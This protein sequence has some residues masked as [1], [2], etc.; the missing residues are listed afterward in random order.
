MRRTICSPSFLFRGFSR[1]VRTNSA[2]A[3]NFRRWGLIGVHQ[4]H[5]PDIFEPI[6]C[7]I[8]KSFYAS[9][10]YSPSPFDLPQLSNGGMIAAFPLDSFT[11]C[12]CADTNG[13]FALPRDDGDCR[14]SKIIWRNGFGRLRLNYDHLAISRYGSAFTVGIDIAAAVQLSDDIR[15]GFSFLNLNRPTIGRRRINCLNFFSRESIASCFRLP[16]CLICDH[17]RCAI[18]SFGPNGGS[19]SADGERRP[20]SR[21]VKRP[22]RDTMRALESGIRQFQWTTAL[23]HTPN[24]D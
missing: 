9:F 4:R 23:Q 8:L 10:F 1:R 18:S 6:S 13:L 17:K 21:R 14:C 22:I 19:V 2:A 15:W 7:R 16:E 11:A 5:R 24:S 20:S 3:G 12:C